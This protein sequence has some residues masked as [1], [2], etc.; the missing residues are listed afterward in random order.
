MEDARLGEHKL[1]ASGHDDSAL[2]LAARAGLALG[3]VERALRMV[4]H[5]A[6]ARAAAP[7][8]AMESV[9]REA[10]S[11]SPAHASTALRLL[12]RELLRVGDYD[13]ARMT[14]DELPAPASP[15][16]AE[17][18]A[19]LRAESH[20]R[21]GEPGAAQRALVAL[22]RAAAKGEAGRAGG[23][24][25]A[26]ARTGAKAKGDAAGSAA[27]AGVM[28]TLAQLAILRGELAPARAT[29]EAIAS[30]TTDVP[31]LEARRAVE[32]A[33]SHLYEERYELTHA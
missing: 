21:A 5:H 31:Q 16:E 13:R 32:I 25:S 30:R 27:S 22:E 8:S 23:K 10:A 12:A 20:I 6:V 18:V 2:V 9:L 28:L 33:A 26:K 7:T 17:R 24:G 15:D 29:L 1:A 3:D 14:L 11:R 4:R 19:L